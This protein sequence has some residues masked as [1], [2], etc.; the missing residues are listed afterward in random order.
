MGIAG[1]VFLGANLLADD[2]EEEEFLQFGR[3]GLLHDNDGSEE[4]LY[5]I[6]GGSA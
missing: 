6:D 1:Q 5:L 3:S 2:A 4:M